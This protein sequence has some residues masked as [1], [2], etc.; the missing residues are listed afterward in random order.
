VY[1]GGE[2]TIENQMP[3]E[4]SGNMLLMFAALAK[5]E[6]NAKYANRYWPQ[7]TQWAEFLKKEGM[8]PG[9]QL[10]TDDFAGHLAHNANLSI[11]A[12]LALGGYSALAE[13]TGRKAEATAYKQLAKEMAS[14]W[15]QMAQDGDHYRLAFDQAGTWSQKYNLVWDRIL[16]L[17]LFHQRSGKRRFVFTRVISIR[18]VCLSITGATTRSS[19]G[20][21][22]PRH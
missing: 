8:D 19:I 5:I 10:S 1:G 6:G 4:E 15:E 12:I 2:R 22:G 18:S 11:K 9:N 13:M 21:C 14:R 7:L 3:V 20:K 16:G 17:N